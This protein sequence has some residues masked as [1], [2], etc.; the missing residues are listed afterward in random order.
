LV[1]L[2]LVLCSFVLPLSQYHYLSS[3]LCVL[4]FF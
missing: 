1:F 4:H 2:C 3:F